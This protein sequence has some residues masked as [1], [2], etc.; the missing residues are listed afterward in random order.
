M[1]ARKPANKKEKN[2]HQ[3]LPDSKSANGDPKRKAVYLCCSPSGHLLAVGYRSATVIFQL[4]V[5]GI[6]RGRVDTWPVHEIKQ[7]KSRSACF[8]GECSIAV[9]YDDGRVRVWSSQTVDRASA[10]RKRPSSSEP[11]TRWQLDAIAETD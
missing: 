10:Q 7:G 1:S 8:L 11:A 2:S 5:S 4:A 9:G 6:D 3:S